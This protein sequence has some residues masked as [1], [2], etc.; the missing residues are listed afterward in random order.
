MNEIK[1]SVLNQIRVKCR[2]GF[3]DYI[4]IY[5][6]GNLETEKLVSL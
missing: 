5:P 1:V 6:L 2:P 3:G 4:C